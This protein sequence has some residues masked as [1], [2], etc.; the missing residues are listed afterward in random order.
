MPLRNRGD[1]IPS[2]VRDEAIEGCA[3]FF[4]FDVVDTEEVMNTYEQRIKELETENTLLKTFNQMKEIIE[5][6]EQGKMIQWYD[7]YSDTWR[8]FD[9]NRNN[10]NF[11]FIHRIKPEEPEEPEKP[12]LAEYCKGIK[13]KTEYYPYVVHP[14]DRVMNVEEAHWGISV[15]EKVLL[16]FSMDLNDRKYTFVVLPTCSAIVKDMLHHYADYPRELANIVFITDEKV[17]V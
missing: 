2:D 4:A 11:N 9:F 1:D 17:V 7:S 10:L 5:A 3:S 13:E 12:T 8:D 6:V 15:P 16:T 14:N